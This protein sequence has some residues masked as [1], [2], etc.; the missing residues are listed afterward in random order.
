[1]K[2]CEKCGSDV[3][4]AKFCP[5]CGAKVEREEAGAVLN[6]SV[7][8][9]SAP[10]TSDEGQD[11]ISASS[12]DYQHAAQPASAS[13]AQETADN[14]SVQATVAKDAIGNTDDAAKDE[15]KKNGKDGDKKKMI[16]II[17]AVVVIVVILIGAIGSCGGNSSQPSSSK[18][19][20]STSSSSSTKAPDFTALNNAIAD[21]EK[22]DPAAYTPESWAALE[23]A[24]TEAK[25]VAEKKNASATEV[26]SATSKLKTAKSGLKEP[27]NPSKYERVSYTDVARNPDSFTGKQLVFSGKVLQVIEG[28]TETN[29]R[30]AT[31]GNYDDVIFVGYDPSIMSS[32]V[33]EDDRI[34]VYGTCTG[35]YTYKSTGAGSISIPGMYATHITIG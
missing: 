35:L 9:D 28:S 20:S 30:V 18:T 10:S 17:I 5:E 3:G 23:T 4:E 12:E 1:M 6:E 33:L 15:E 22:L 21:A 11:A 8:S 16:G 14:T 25:T 27:F 31:S 19:S 29:L 2:R 32:R 7:A 13:D 34:T 24:L 26:S